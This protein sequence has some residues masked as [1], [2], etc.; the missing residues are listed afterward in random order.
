M[1]S[2]SWRCADAVTQIC[3]RV[4]AKLLLLLPL[5]TCDWSHDD[6]SHHY[7]WA[8]R[9][10]TLQ[11]SAVPSVAVLSL[12][13]RQISSKLVSIDDRITQ[14]I[15][16]CIVSGL[17]PVCVVLLSAGRHFFAF[18]VTSASPVTLFSTFHGLT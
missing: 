4:F 13:F 6:A 18:S 5:T 11:C 15:R 14:I 16:L 1:Q 17:H 10:R 9:R 12:V 3:C 7:D 8:W 2:V